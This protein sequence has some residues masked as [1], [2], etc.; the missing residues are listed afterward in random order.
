MRTLVILVDGMRPDS[1][2]H[3]EKAQAIMQRSSYT[4]EAATV[5]PSVTLPCHMSLFH[6]V[7]PAR[8]G[9]TTNTY[10]PQVRPINGLC[11]VLLKENKKS[12]FFYNWEELRDLARPNSLEFSYFCKAYLFFIR[13]SAL[14]NKSPRCA[15]L[16]P[17]FFAEILH[18]F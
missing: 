18:P 6:S 4:M 10:T 2:T 16:C 12:A 11:E 7:D 8:H 5:M 14:V 1:L 9:V 15:K 3:M 17:D 13:N